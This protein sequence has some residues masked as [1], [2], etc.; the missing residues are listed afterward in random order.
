MIRY[1]SYAIC[2]I[3]ESIA[4][5]QGNLSKR[6][7]KEIRRRDRRQPKA[8]AKEARKYAKTKKRRR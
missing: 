8:E 1:G 6:E 2:R 4:M 7:L 3:K 5:R